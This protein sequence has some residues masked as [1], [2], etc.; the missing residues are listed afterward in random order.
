MKYVSTRGQAPVLG[1][2]DVLLAG[3][4]TDGGLYVP[5]EYPRFSVTEMREMRSMSYPDL[6]AK[7]MAPFT[8]GCLSEKELSEITHQAYGRFSHDAVALLKQVNDGLWVMELFYGPTLAFK[9]YALQTVGLM[10]DK[11]LHRRGAH[12]TIVGATSGDTGSAAIEACKD[13]DGLDIFILH[14]HNRVSEVQRRQM[15]TVLS[16]NV[17]NIALEGTFD[18]CQSIVKALFADAPFRQTYALSAVNSINWARIMAQVVYYFRAALSLGAPDRDIS[19]AVPTGNFGNVFAGYV[20]K[21]MGLPIRK[22]ILGSNANDILPRFLETGEMRKKEV[23]PSISPSMDIQ[24]SSNFE[25]LLFEA[26]GRDAAAVARLM[27]TFKYENYY[28]VSKEALDRIRSDFCGIRCDDTETKE[29]IAKIFRESGELL[30]PHSAIGV[31]AAEKCG[32]K[33]TPTV[34]LATAHP[35]KFPVPVREATGVTPVLPPRLSD[36]LTRK[37]V[38]TVLP[39]SVD[40]IKYFI[41]THV[42]GRDA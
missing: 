2:E 13:R 42:R 23:H 33:E 28:I 14:P 38:F 21:E 1:F 6:A 25:R 7:V 5:Q 12:I 24:V 20:A 15:T 40:A 19:F 32:E 9:D 36:L 18:D 26:C 37:E 22:L 27:E 8:A 11:V 34:V 16:P 39:N 35:S 31:V 29:E 10:F 30:D 41:E 4:A 17:F 3:L